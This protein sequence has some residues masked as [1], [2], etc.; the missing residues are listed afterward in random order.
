MGAGAGDPAVGVT[1]D[2]GLSV[3]RSIDDGP[4]N[5]DSAGD[6]PMAMC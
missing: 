5:G 3:R 6:A 4:F 2:A 1:D